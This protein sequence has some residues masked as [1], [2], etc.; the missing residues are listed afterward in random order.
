MSLT[1]NDKVS[2]DGARNG[3]LPASRSHTHS[4]P[5][6]PHNPILPLLHYPDFDNHFLIFLK[7]LPLKQYHLVLSIF[8]LYWLKW[9]YLATFI[10]YHT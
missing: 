8:E 7:V 10:Q 5:L 4:A 1:N 2:T 6:P 9:L 3:T